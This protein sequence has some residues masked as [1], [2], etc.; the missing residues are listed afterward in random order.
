MARNYVSTC[1]CPHPKCILW[2]REGEKG[3]TT[4]KLDHLPSQHGNQ[5]HLPFPD[6]A[7]NT[8]QKGKRAQ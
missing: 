4:Q 6:E 8:E 2:V 1:M 5:L 3:S 7:G